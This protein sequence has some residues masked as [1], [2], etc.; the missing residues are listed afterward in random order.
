MTRNDFL[1]KHPPL[2]VSVPDILGTLFD[3]DEKVCV[4]VFDDK[5]TRGAAKWDFPCKDF[6]KFKPQ[7][8]Q[9]NTDGYCIS[10]VI[11]AGGQRDADITRINS[12]YI[13]MDDGALDEQMEK[14]N[15]FP[16]KPSLIVV[17]QKSLHC[18]WFAE[19]S[20]D[21]LSRFRE[22]QKALIRHFGSDSAICNES[23]PMRL[24]GFYHNKTNVPVKVEVIAFDPSLRYTPDQLAEA[25]PLS[26]P[27]TGATNV[28]AAPANRSLHP[29]AELDFIARSCAFIRYCVDNAKVLSEP[30]WHAMITNLALFEGGAELIHQYSSPYPKY[31]K[32]GTDRKIKRFL[33]SGV[34]PTTCE[35][36]SERGFKCPLHD[37]GL[38]AGKAPAAICHKRLDK[39]MLFQMVDDMVPTG[40]HDAD[41]QAA[42]EYVRVLLKSQ[43]KRT[44]KAAIRRLTD[45]FNLQPADSEHLQHIYDDACGNTSSASSGGNGSN[46]NN[47]SGSL[48]KGRNKGH[49]LGPW[50]KWTNSGIKFMPLILAEHIAKTFHIIYS[51]SMFYQFENGVY[52]PVSDET[53]G[54][55]IQSN[56]EEESAK[57]SQIM[58]TLNQLRIKVACDTSKLNPDPSI[59]NI[60]NGLLDVHTRDLIPHTHAFLSTI[61]LKASYD[62][63]A[64][65]PRFKK[66]LFDSME[67]D[68]S[69]VALIQEMLGYCLVPINSAQVCFVLVGAASAGKSVLLRVINDLLLGRENVS[70]IP[71]QSLGDR[72][73]SANLFGKLANIFADLPTKNIDDDGLFKALSGEDFITGERKFKDEFS[74]MNFAKLLFSCN[75]LPKN[76]ADRSDG[77]YRRLVL[78]TF[79]HSVPVDQR[80]P[81]LLD[82]FRAE[83][84]GI[85]L[86]ALDGLTRLMANNYK[87]SLSQ[88]NLDRLQQYREESDSALAFLRDN[89][90]VG[91]NFCVGSTELFNAYEAYCKESGMKPFAHKTFVQHLIN[92]EPS[93]TKGKDTLG[94]RR[95]LNG[96][97]L[98]EIL[99]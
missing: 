99:G 9:L 98:G 50:Y 45:R 38:C 37:K 25:L 70:N 24:P 18:Y 71:W 97:R 49:P 84:D 31:S 16:L 87:F 44:A 56:L 89:C 77:F 13:D 58:D 65:C 30:L 48:S 15:A 10:L 32:S 14:I 33:D 47:G 7:L 52:H 62:P 75:I 90:E 2:H 39:D 20:S 27:L 95:V 40:T 51:A 66:F 91:S 55:I 63:S 93:I 1:V 60:R 19:D 28:A 34:G 5:G 8:D 43:K 4:R 74:F 67:G 85:F 21:A 82:K 6:H 81:F 22:I 72:F 88:V 57:Y 23:R 69:Q 53:I 76:Y 73:K 59:I 79:N 11:N 83:V 94:K 64:D 3:P 17:T 29:K 54:Q 78:I 12:Y 86:F 92:H 26:A 96:I 36:I 42:E 41:I 35:I 80:D 68:A 46:S 61:Q